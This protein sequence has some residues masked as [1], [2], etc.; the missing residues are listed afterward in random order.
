MGFTT[1]IYAHFC[2]GSQINVV[3]FPCPKNILRSVIRKE[4]FAFS[5]LVPK[6]KRNHTYRCIQ[7]TAAT[8]KT[9][10]VN[11]T[12]VFDMFKSHQLPQYLFQWQ[13]LYCYPHESL[14]LQHFLLPPI[15][16]SRTFRQHQYDL[17]DCWHSMKRDF[18]FLSLLSIISSAL[19]N[20]LTWGS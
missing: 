16:L 19:I 6:S 1:I 10:M 18:V 2:S 14:H 5:Q 11:A 17:Q 12:I 9:G 3:A 20:R 8:I 15:I 7:N 13:Q 4:N